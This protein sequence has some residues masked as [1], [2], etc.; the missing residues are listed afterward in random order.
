MHKIC[1]YSASTQSEGDPAERSRG[2]LGACAG[3]A[4]TRPEAGDATAYRMFTTK[5]RCIRFPHSSFAI[6]RWSVDEHNHCL[7]SAVH[8][9]SPA[10]RRCLLEPASL[11]RSIVA[12]SIGPRAEWTLLSALSDSNGGCSQAALAETPH[13][14]AAVEQC[15]G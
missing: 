2:G 4:A 11:H 10:C 14:G 7:P 9:A 8:C 13:I 6:I 3:N 5:S 12:D 15:Q 1:L